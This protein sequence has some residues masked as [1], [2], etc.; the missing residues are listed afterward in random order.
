MFSGSVPKYF[1]DFNTIVNDRVLF[2]FFIS[3]SNFLL[4]THIG[5]INYCIL[6]LYLSCDFAKLTY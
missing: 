2:L 6:T 1:T 5:T 4:L 3:V